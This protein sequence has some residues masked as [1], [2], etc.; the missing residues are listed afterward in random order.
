MPID[1]NGVPTLNNITNVETEGQNTL[2]GVESPQVSFGNMVERLLAELTEA[3][4]VYVDVTNRKI[5]AAEGSGIGGVI[6][7]LADGDHQ[8]LIA[9]DSS[10]SGRSLTW[11][12]GTPGASTDNELVD[13]IDST[14][15]AAKPR[16]SVGSLVNAILASVPDEN[17]IYGP[18]GI[19]VDQVNGNLLVIGRSGSAPGTND[20]VEAVEGADKGVTVEFSEPA[21]TGSS[22]PLKFEG[23]AV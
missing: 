18:K 15:T 6:T 1:S 3:G 14:I 8:H 4:Q 12:K 2:L 10:Q 7:D 11:T 20:L 9:P 5:Y 16:R 13:Y 19:L 22:N 21:D 23:G 17:L